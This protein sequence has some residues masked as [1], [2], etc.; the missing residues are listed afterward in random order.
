MNADRIAE[1]R[2]LAEESTDYTDDSY[3]DIYDGPAPEDRR[4]MAFLT[5]ARGAMIEALDAIE[6]VRAL[7][8][9]WDGDPLREWCAEATLAALE[10][11]SG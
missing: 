8:R 5:I 10:G 2:A 9:E 3:I 11:K 1:L 4:D 7:M 6:R